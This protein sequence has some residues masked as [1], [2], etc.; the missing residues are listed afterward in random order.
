MQ[1][2]GPIPNLLVCA[3]RVGEPSKLYFNRP[4]K[5]ILMLSKV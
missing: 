2:L 5:G 1:A 3:W 4:S